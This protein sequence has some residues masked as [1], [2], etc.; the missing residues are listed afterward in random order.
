[1]YACDCDPVMCNIA[2][3]CFALNAAAVALMRSHSS[4]MMPQRACDILLTETLD[5]AI[6]GERIVGILRFRFA[7]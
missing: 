7:D 3:D 6:F 1:M 2:E 5:S 4:A